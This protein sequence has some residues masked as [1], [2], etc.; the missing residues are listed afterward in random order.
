MQL[1]AGITFSLR[2]LGTSQ[3]VLE[4]WSGDGAVQGVIS[5]LK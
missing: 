5:P 3:A 1:D 4:D 2:D